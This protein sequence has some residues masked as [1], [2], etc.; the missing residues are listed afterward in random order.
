MQLIEDYLID[1]STKRK[2]WDLSIVVLFNIYFSHVIT[3]FLFAIS[4]FDRSENWMIKY[5]IMDMDWYVKYCYGYYW[6]TTIV[7]TT[8]FGDLTAS[9]LN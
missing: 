1:N 8:G 3:S 2:Y 6:A 5:G 9:N 4:F 7:S